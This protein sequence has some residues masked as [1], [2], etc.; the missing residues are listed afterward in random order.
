VMVV[1]PIHKAL[2]V[3]LGETL[4]I[5]LADNSNPFYLF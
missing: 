1:Q 4:Y 2:G 5:G 3:P